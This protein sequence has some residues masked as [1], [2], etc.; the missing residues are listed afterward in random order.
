MRLL[1]PFALL[2]CFLP[3]AHALENARLSPDGASEGCPVTQGEG[4]NANPAPA[5][6]E[7]A[8]DAAATA[9]ARG[10]GDPMQPPSKPQ[11]S[12]ARWQSLLPGMFR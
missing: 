8:T 11:R 9:P 6:R 3:S 7:D 4:Q 2:L 12:P 1:L 10:P 5:A